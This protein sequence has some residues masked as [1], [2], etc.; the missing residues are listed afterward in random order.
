MKSLFGGSAVLATALLSAFLLV[1]ATPSLAETLLFQLQQ[2]P[3]QIAK[4]PSSDSPTGSSLA[5]SPGI[6]PPGTLSGTVIEPKESEL[7][8]SQPMSYVA[9]AYSL[10][11][12]TASGRFVSQGIIAADPRVLPL[13]SRVRLEAGAWSGEYL[14]ADTGGAIRGRKIDIWTPSTREAMR[15]GRRNVKL[16]ILSYGGKRSARKRA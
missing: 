15:F 4:S 2:E 5:D 7:P 8:V 9:T 13:G 1:S 12:R 11:G 6:T 14:V 16:T 3:Q 10:R